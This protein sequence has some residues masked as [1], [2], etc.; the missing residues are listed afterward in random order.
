[1]KMTKFQCFCEEHTIFSRG[2][3][4][5]IQHNIQGRTL[6]FKWLSTRYTKKFLPYI[7]TLYNYIITLHYNISVHLHAGSNLKHLPRLL[8]TCPCKFLARVATPV[9]VTCGVPES[10]KRPWRVFAVKNRLVITISPYAD[11]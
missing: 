3:R 5:V 8:L 2:G 1:M 4:F 6:H 10:V 9:L 11:R 7:I